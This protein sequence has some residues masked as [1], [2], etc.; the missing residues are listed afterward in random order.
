M[1]I[2]LSI[3]CSKIVEKLLRKNNV[4]L[5]MSYKKILM[6][7]NH[8]SLKYGRVYITKIN[9]K[10]KTKIEIKM[11]IKTSTIKCSLIPFSLLK[12]KYINN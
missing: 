6:D 5:I 12:Q 10:K 7:S 1:E 9:K 4:L 8:V 3:N 11:K 2:K